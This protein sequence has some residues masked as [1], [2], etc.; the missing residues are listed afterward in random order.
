ME[1][2]FC[3]PTKNNLRYLTGC[4][5]SI[6]QNSVHNHEII[7]Y[8]DSDVDGTEQWLIQNNVKYLK[9]DSV[10][11]KGIAHG[12]NRC[13]EAASKDVVCMFHADMYMAKGFDVGLTKHLKPKTVV[14]ATRIE[15]PLHPPGL[16]KIV[17]NCGLYPETF[18]VKLFDKFVDGCVAKNSGVTT[19]G[20]FAPW[21]IHKADIAAI[22]MHDEAFHSYHEDSDIFNRFVLSG[23]DIIQSWD[24]YVYH[25]TCRGGQFQDG[26]EKITDDLDFHKMKRNAFRNYVRKWK[27][28]IRNDEYHYPLFPNVYNVKFNITNCNYELL[29][30]FEPWC[31]SIQT[32]MKGY[33]VDEYVKNEGG[34]SIDN[35]AKKTKFFDKKKYDI[36]LSFD[37]N[38][39]NSNT[40]NIIYLLGSILDDNKPMTGTYE[41]QNGFELKVNKLK[42]ISETLI[43]NN[44]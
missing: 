23:Y 29:Y 14:S 13:I 6:R 12:Y 4:I 34:V 22:G 21:C 35:I 5:N 32:D 1:I 18:D 8:I 42:S 19:R 26:V 17:E 3:I 38:S 30:L 41:I 44:G 27:S 9:N 43:V 25:F 15:P 7:V 10:V 20:I 11:P 37:G 33:D 36:E 16:E 28:L 24:S 39:I 31:S 2:T 40:I